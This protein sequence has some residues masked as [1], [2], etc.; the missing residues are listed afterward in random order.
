MISYASLL[1]VSIFCYIYS[2]A[3]SPSGYNKDPDPFSTCVFFIGVR[4][5]LIAFA[6]LILPVV[7]HV[8]MTPNLYLIAGA[9][10]VGTSVILQYAFAAI[11]KVAQGHPIWDIVQWAIEL[12]NAVQAVAV[13]ALILPS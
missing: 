9:A 8:V 11:Q 12:L 5:L 3:V 6:F 2:R 10:A 7:T 13:V 1:F 4:C